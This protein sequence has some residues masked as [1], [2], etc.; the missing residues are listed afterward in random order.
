[1]KHFVISGNIGSGKS[2]L[3]EVLKREIK[4]KN[5]YHF[6]DEPVDVW[7]SIK[8]KDGI[9]ALQHYYNNPRKNAYNLQMLALITRMEEMK[10]ANEQ[11][12][13]IIVSERCLHEDKEIFAKLLTTDGF[14]TEIEYETYKYYFDA[15]K[16]KEP[17]K[18]FYINTHPN[19]CLNRI[20]KRNRP[21]EGDISVEYLRKL[22]LYYA[23]WLC[24]GDI[25]V[26]FL[27]GKKTPEEL[28]D[29][30]LLMIL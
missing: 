10:K 23:E 25:D 5:K 29:E 2:T 28:A 27:D 15:F 9:N 26:T 19:E 7:K 22:H 12:D 30:I 4:N 13:K 14:I 18:I 1:M 16:L 8:D 20:K 21:E 11:E 6:I 3:L 17:T 24:G